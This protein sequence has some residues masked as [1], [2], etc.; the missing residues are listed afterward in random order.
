MGRGGQGGDSGDQGSTAANIHLLLDSILSARLLTLP[1]TTARPPLWRC[2][3]MQP[4]VNEVN[5]P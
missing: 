2:A 4:C 5:I 1:N 3:G